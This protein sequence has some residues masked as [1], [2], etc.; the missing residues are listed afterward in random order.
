M[1]N[2]LLLVHLCVLL[3]VAFAVPGFAQK[4]PAKPPDET[5]KV[6]T[7]VKGSK[8]KAH[9]VSRNIWMIE[10]E[11]GS[12]IVVAEA[13]IFI[14]FT[15]LAR[16]SDFKPTAETFAAMLRYAGEADF[17]KI[18]LDD[19]GDLVLRIEATTRSVVQKDFNAIVEQVIAA[20]GEAARKL[21]PFLVKN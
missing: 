14:V 5:A 8:L 3:V 18:A 16:A 7:L 11:G 9:L 4:R 12:I 19:N 6:A 17:V 10:P 2:R 20:S 13:D 21:Q 1:F 15:V